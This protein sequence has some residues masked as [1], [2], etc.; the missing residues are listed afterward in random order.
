MD[1]RV[2]LD[3]L[4]GPAAATAAAVE[5]FEAA[6][7]QAAPEASS[8]TTTEVNQEHHNVLCVVNMFSN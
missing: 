5:R 1:D 6:R 3:P 8:S 2:T 4:P 7:L